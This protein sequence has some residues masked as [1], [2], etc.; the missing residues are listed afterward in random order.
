[1]LELDVGTGLFSAMI[2]EAI[3]CVRLCLVDLAP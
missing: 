2:L 1:M 3:P